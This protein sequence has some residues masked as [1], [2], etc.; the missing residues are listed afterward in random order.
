MDTTEVD[1]WL[2]DL[3]LVRMSKRT[4]EVLLGTASQISEGRTS[5]DEICSVIGVNPTYVNQMFGSRSALLESAAGYV[6]RSEVGHSVEALTEVSG[7]LSRPH[8]V[9]RATAE[10]FTSATVQLADSRRT[11][12]LHALPLLVRSPSGR[13]RLGV[14]IQ[15]PCRALTY[16]LRDWQARWLARDEFDPVTRAYFMIGLLLAYVVTPVPRRLASDLARQAALLVSSLADVGDSR[17]LALDSWAPNRRPSKLPGRMNTLEESIDQL[18]PGDSTWFR[19]VC[20]RSEEEAISSAHHPIPISEICDQLGISSRSIYRYFPTRPNFEWALQSVHAF[21]DWAS[22]ESQWAEFRSC[23]AAAEVEHL[24]S[25]LLQSFADAGS[26]ARRE[27]R[28]KVIADRYREDASEAFGLAVQ[29]VLERCSAIVS[30]LQRRGLVAESVDSATFPQMMFMIDVSRSICDCAAEPIPDA[31]WGW[32]C[33]LMVGSVF[34]SSNASVFRTRR[35]TA[36]TITQP[37]LY[38]S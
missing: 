8:D 30:Q 6:V 7:Q 26:R 19:E 36:D 12:L 15:E 34:A 35:G 21:S 4:R 5:V 24:V 18:V 22:I 20:R 1:R 25:D 14:A 33:D 9:G 31:S 38:L 28:L 23:D 17:T 11:A 13:Q 16:S 32:E 10:W 29:G 2:E 3:H 27:L 37:R